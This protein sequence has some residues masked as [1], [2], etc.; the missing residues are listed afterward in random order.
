MIGGTICAIC[1]GYVRAQNLD[2]SV[3]D[4]CASD[5]ARTRARVDVLV[6][7]TNA[8]SAPAHLVSEC[9]SGAPLR[10]I[11]PECTVDSRYAVA[12]ANEAV[13]EMII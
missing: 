2:G 7:T 5:G 12:Y 10:S 13:L 11:F 8:V 3:R 4:R 9:T 6:R 1:A